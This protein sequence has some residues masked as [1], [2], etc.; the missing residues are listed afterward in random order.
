MHACMMLCHPSYV[1]CRSLTFFK[2][3]IVIC[4]DCVLSYVLCLG[5]LAH[6]MSL[7]KKMMVYYSVWD[8]HCLVTILPPADEECSM[9]I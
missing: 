1:L 3:S 4:V 2:K 5:V 9:V 8:H 7:P 6:I